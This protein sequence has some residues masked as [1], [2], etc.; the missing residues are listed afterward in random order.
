MLELRCYTWTMSFTYHFFGRCY[1]LREVYER[2][3]SKVRR[4]KKEGIAITCLLIFA[5]AVLLPCVSGCGS[6]GLNISIYDGQ[7]ETRLSTKVGITVEQALEEAEIILGEQ[8][9]VSPSLNTTLSDES[10]DISIERY[11]KVTV[12]DHKQSY[13]IEMTGA[14]VQDAVKA[15]E[16][17]LGKYD[18]IS[19]D[20]DAYL[21][22]GMD[23]KVL[24]R[25]IVYIDVDGEQKDY[26][27][28]APTVKEFLEEQGIELGEKDLVT[29]NLD[30]S[31]KNGIQVAIQRVSERE[32]TEYEPIPFDTITEYSDSMYQGETLEK[33]QGRKGEKELIYKVS[34]VDGEEA[35]RTLMAERVIK[36]PVSH[37]LVQGTAVRQKTTAPPQVHQQT[38]A[39]PSQTPAPPPQAPSRTII[40]RE[41]IYDCDGSG[42]GYYVITWSDGKVEYQDF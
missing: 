42:H 30:Q 18:T 34:Y 39:P 24:H 15:A 25:Y 26:I 32:I 16:I 37:V 5:Q 2:T 36:E 17:N 20:L 7:T 23:I 10:V 3:K 19:H 4:L 33:Q 13:D 29:P 40:S 35:E 14:K 9:K 38:P 28:S 22:D 27:S 11:T 12:K 21:T 1:G 8:D 6:K 41:P 31:L